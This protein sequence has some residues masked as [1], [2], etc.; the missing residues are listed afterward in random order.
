MQ[1]H[2][3][4]E[5]EEVMFD[6]ASLLPRQNTTPKHNNKQRVLK[7]TCLLAAFFGLVRA[8]RHH[9]RL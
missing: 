1:R 5:D 7:T 4:D 9:F 8:K 6:R 2:V 3:D